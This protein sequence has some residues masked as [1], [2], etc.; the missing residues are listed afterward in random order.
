VSEAEF[1]QWDAL[2]FKL[3]NGMVK[4]IESLQRKQADGDWQDSFI[5]KESNAAYGNME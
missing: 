2:A 3:E 4:L 5:L 1:E